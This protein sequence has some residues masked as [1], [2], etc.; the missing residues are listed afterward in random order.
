M[1]QIMQHIAAN[2]DDKTNVHLVFGNVTEE[3]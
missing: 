3:E 2:K 1:W